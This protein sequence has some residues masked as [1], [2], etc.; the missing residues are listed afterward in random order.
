M[1]PISVSI[2]IE[3]VGR[4]IVVKDELD[5]FI[6]ELV[7]CESGGNNNAV[8]DHGLALGILQYHQPT[9]DSF[10]KKYGIE[11]D[12]MNQDV[13]RKLTRLILENEKEGWRH[14]FNCSRS[15]GLPPL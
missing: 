13:Q 11:G 9:F 7:Q 6:E 12:I 10:S 14:W 5:E 8:G 3:V 2:F 15:I 4:D 1:P